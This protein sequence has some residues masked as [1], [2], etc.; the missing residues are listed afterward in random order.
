MGFIDRLLGREI[1]TLD[2]K[3]DDFQLIDTSKI[4]MPK[5]PP[6]DV[7]LDA[8]WRYAKRSEIVFACIEKK[9]TAATDAVLVVEQRGTDG[10]WEPL[11]T[12]PLISLLS[13][14]NPY[15]DGESFIRT[16]IESENFADNFYCEIVRSAAGVPV[17]LYPL[18]P[19]YLVP[20][21][22]MGERGWYIDHYRYFQTGYPVRLEVDDIL[23]RRRHGLG[24]IYSEVS[25]MAVALNSIDADTSA[26]EYVRAFWNNGGAP[27]GVLAI[28]GRTLTDAEVQHI[29]QQWTSRYGRNGSNRMG[30]AILPEGTTYSPVSSKL[31]E[32][33]NE[34][35]N[36]D[37]VSKICMIFGVPPIIINAV[38]GLKHVTQNATAQAAMGEFWAHTMSPELKSIRNFLTWNLLPMFEDINKIKAGQIRCNWD[39]SQVDAMQEDIDAVHSRVGEGYQN[40]I[41]TLNEARSKV[42]LPEVSP[43]QGGD[44]FFKPPAPIAPQDNQPPKPKPPK[45]DSYHE[46]SAADISLAKPRQIP[47]VLNGHNGSKK[48][49]EYQGL[50][51][52]RE[53]SE[54]EKSI[55]LKAIYDSYEQGRESLSKVIK[56]MRGD[57]I[58]Q[59]VKEVRDFGDADI[60]TLTLS[61][62]PYATKSIT[63]EVSKAVNDGRL[64][65][66]KEAPKNYEWQFVSEKG[67]ID[68]LIRILVETTIS[69]VITEVS[70]AAINIF[71]ALRKLGLDREEVESRMNEELVL[72]SEKSFDRI[73]QGTINEAV[74]A[75]RREEM[76]ARSD[77]IDRYQYSA[78][79]DKNTCEPCAEWDGFE[80]EDLDAMP[81]TP[82]PEC[83]GG[84]SCR[85]FIISIFD[86]EA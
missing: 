27:S 41:Y 86:T 3:R 39:L 80:S 45:S 38:V 71:T 21:W 78:I 77:E 46:L 64:Q 18:N 69:Q 51:L 35:L 76:E 44:E 58:K 55:D 4:G 13:K 31:N 67:V 26:T 16:W 34:T 72:R 50:T 28:A 24:S 12:H 84:S 63:R 79:L 82:N 65:I 70:T 62:P 56:T 83:E 53:P 60:H 11:D 14:P 36:D 66:A 37:A 43:E 85:C 49:F 17:Q 40:G 42:G 1:T 52:A 7:S 81:E 5:P 20:Q 74:N 75:G 33:N 15:D 59:A 32:L 8:T 19:V 6:L 25:Q 22:Y 61:P 73:S 2:L 54:L 10:E 68:D 23:V 9:A 30:P 29:Q 47:A 57:L 48:N